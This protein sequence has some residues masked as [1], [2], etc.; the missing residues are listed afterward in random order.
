[1]NYV[2][3]AAAL[4]APELS[5]Q[6]VAGDGADGTVSHFDDVLLVVTDGALVAESSHVRDFQRRLD[7]QG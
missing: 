7:Q 5:A 2:V 1:M 4:V 6:L 3:D